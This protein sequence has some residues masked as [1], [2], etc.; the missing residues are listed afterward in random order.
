MIEAKCELEEV[1]FH[2]LRLGSFGDRSLSLADRVIMY[3]RRNKDEVEL[4]LQSTPVQYE[5]PCGSQSKRRRLTSTPDHYAGASF[6][7]LRSPPC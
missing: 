7:T 5:A 2:I 4:H 1:D 3:G 6:I